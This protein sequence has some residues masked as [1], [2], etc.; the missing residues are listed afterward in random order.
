ME[1]VQGVR[2]D[3][4]AQ[5]QQEEQY[6]QRSVPFEDWPHQRDEALGIWD[7]EP[8]V[9]RVAHGVKNRGHRLAELGNAVVPQIPEIIG[10]AI[11]RSLA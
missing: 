1:T 2:H 6:M 5:S 4:S 11:L 9:P 10:R 3:V 8:E 7:R